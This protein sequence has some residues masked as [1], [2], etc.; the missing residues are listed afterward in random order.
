MRR[1]QEEFWCA[2]GG[3]GC[4]KYFLTWLRQNMNGEYTIQCPNCGHHHFRKIVDGLVTS[5]RHDLRSG[6]QEIIIGL[7]TTLR[8]E[9]WT[10]DPEFRRRQLKAYNG[11]QFV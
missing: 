7:K 4:G 11:G 8:D 2:T 10:N 1:R 9:P 3:G 5:D 6:T